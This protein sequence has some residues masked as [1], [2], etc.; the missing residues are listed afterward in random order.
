MN[1]RPKLLIATF[2]LAASS[3]TVS[4]QTSGSPAV[5]A[6][7]FAPLPTEAILDFIENNPEAFPPET[8]RRLMRGYRSV[9]A[10]G[11]VATAQP[12][13]FPGRMFA[14]APTATPV[15]DHNPPCGPNDPSLDEEWQIQAR[16][17][18]DRAA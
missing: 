17:P 18:N 3:F 4:A 14:V 12:Y 16:A 2:S 11:E 5:P 13:F 15:R 7:P 6:S 9:I 10:R 8:K 1:V